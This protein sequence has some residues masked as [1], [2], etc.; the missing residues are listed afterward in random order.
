LLQ[1]DGTI[2]NDPIFDD[3]QA[4]KRFQQALIGK[5]LPTVDYGYMATVYEKKMVQ[6]GGFAAGFVQ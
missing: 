6:D 3:G 1:S 4:R 2:S 5:R